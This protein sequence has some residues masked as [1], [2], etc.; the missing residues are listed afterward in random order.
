M[1]LFLGNKEVLVHYN[2]NVPYKMK[3][4]T[5]KHGIKKERPETFC[6]VLFNKTDGSSFLNIS[7]IKVNLNEL[8]TIHVFNKRI[9]HLKQ[10]VFKLEQRSLQSNEK[11]CRCCCELK[12]YK[13]I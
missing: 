2:F 4:E 7:A 6:F 1:S 10:I 3:P 5:E 11:V 9:I 13:N 12:I 8:S